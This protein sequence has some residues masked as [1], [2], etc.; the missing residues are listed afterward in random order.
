MRV[1]HV[2]FVT[3]VKVI[4]F[5]AGFLRLRSYVEKRGR[6]TRLP[7]LPWA[8]HLFYILQNLANHLRENK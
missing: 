6:V 8:S 7:E 5:V 4:A 1:F 3:V 2:H